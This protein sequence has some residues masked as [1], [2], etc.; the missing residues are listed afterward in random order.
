MQATLLKSPPRPTRLNGP[1]LSPRA[2]P[3]PIIDAIERGYASHVASSL[4][5]QILRYSER[6]SLLRAADRLHI[7][8]FR[9]NLIIAMVQHER[10]EAPAPKARSSDVPRSRGASLST[11]SM[12]A[13]VMLVELLLITACWWQLA[14]A[15]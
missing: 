15:N 1:G 8:R 13:A 3:T 2:L 4:N 11:A 5:G 10:G 14:R 12:L 6:Q 7:N 9:A